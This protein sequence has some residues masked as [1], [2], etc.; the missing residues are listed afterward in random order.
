MP[1]SYNLKDRLDELFSGQP[2]AALPDKRQT[3]GDGRPSSEQHLG[4][5]T[6]PVGMMLGVF[7][8][9]FAHAGVGVYLTHTDGRFFRINKV[10][11]D[12]LDYS[13]EELIGKSF[14]EITYIEDRALGS[15]AMQA[16]LDGKR[17]SASFQKRYVRK[18]GGLVWVSLDV[19]ALRDHED[20]V[21]CFVTLA[22]D[23]NAQINSTTAL[24]AVNQAMQTINQ[25]VELNE[26]LRQM[27]EQAIRRSGYEVGLI[28]FYDD[29]IG[30]L[31]LVEHRGLPEAMYQRVKEH[32]FSNTPCELVFKLG[33]IVYAQDIYHLPDDAMEWM[34]VFDGPKKFGFKAYF[35]IPFISEGKVFG[36]LCM[37]DYAEKS[38]SE[39]QKDVLRA[40]SQQVSVSFHRAEQ[41]RQNQVALAEN[42]ALYEGGA[43]IIAATNP[44]QVLKALIGSSGLRQ[45]DRVNLLLFDAVWEANPPEKLVVG[46]VWEKSGG[47][48]LESIGGVY[49]FDLYSFENL[50][51]RD[52]PVHIPD[53][54]TDARLCENFSS[55]LTRMGACCISV[56]PLISGGQWY[57]VLT[58]QASK[59]I[60]IA[61]KETR[62]ISSLIDQAA[63]VLRGL[64]LQEEMS[65]KVRE[66][67]ALQR[68][69][70]R[71]AWVAYQNQA[72]SGSQGYFYNQ[73]RIEP[74]GSRE[75]V[76]DVCGKGSQGNQERK[77][78]LAIRG[79]TIGVLGIR[80]DHQGSLS[81]E[82]EAFL[83]AI[84]DQVALAME[85]A[86]L[87]EQTQK[88][89]VELQAVADLSTASASIL[90][91]GELLQTVVDMT[92]ANFGLYHA[93][94]YLLDDD[95]LNLVLSVGAGDVGRSMVSEGWSIPISEVNSVVA[96]AARTGSG[97]VFND[98]RNQEG[99]LP[100]PL[101][102]DTLSELAVPLKV[103]DKLLGVFDV[104][105]NTANRFTEE[106]VRI[107]TTLAAQS[108]VAL[109]NAKL[110]E[111]QLEIVD[112]LRE[113]GNMKSAFLANMSHELRT[114]L[115]SILGFTQVILEGLDGPLTDMM[116]SDLELIEKN[117]KHLLSLINDVLDLA[118]IEAG[119]FTLSP[120]PVNVYDLMEE[121]IISNSA[122]AREKDL[123]MHLDA[124]PSE[125]WTV[126]ADQVRLRQIFINL[127][128]NAIKFTETGGLTIELERIWAID[129]GEEDKVQLRVRDTGIG[130]PKNKLE[131]IFE[132]FSQVDSSTTRKVG[133]TGLGLPISRRLM[134]LHGG[135]L[136]AESTSQAGE[137]SVFFLE[138]PVVSKEEVEPE[139]AA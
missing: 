74:I 37:F 59:A 81:P 64:Q 93:H 68:M 87:I 1:R 122:L 9:V 135:R 90:N 72:R 82:D 73:A 75:L 46:A 38:V 107:Y 130:I 127:I 58:A 32:G 42:K 12:L 97:Q 62:W 18:D 10:F 95:G 102:P 103:G 86:R 112:K 76:N 44:D 40:I 80:D 101:L 123:F 35:G 5:S 19:T 36:T 138:L 31:R 113:L 109:Q 121:V 114:P 70:S 104:Q 52:Q 45:F 4:D 3:P 41:Y 25:T 111:E 39:V 129:G 49:A 89:A 94:A 124:E 51:L 26:I 34:G 88:A 132:A 105:A 56:Y 17:E 23:I 79:E 28:S 48:P 66:L 11:A 133:G 99:Y 136:W 54:T 60:A 78:P 117:G 134:E 71:E 110:Y 69:M 131:T 108:A 30:A 96:R 119:R 7:E 116:V 8:L 29:E 55:L 15:A 63:T 120:E 137:G 100:N 22:E 118:K 61:E 92:K 139:G 20:R 50:F 13:I 91:P 98:V 2:P 16:M 57:G 83:Q 126:S 65:E 125:F 24:E 53:V 77:I 84:S 43:R 21:L 47:N 6:D 33:R 27:L 128:G 85:R 14:Q 115:N 106:D 67:T